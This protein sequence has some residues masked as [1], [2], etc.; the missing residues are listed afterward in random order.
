MMVSALS[1]PNL[2]AFATARTL[3]LR[4][5][6]LRDWF[7]FRFAYLF[8]VKRIAIGEENIPTDGPAI[9]IMN[10]IA[11]IDPVVVGGVKVR[12]VTPLAKK[13]VIGYP[14]LNWLVRSWG[15]IPVDRMAID[16]QALLQV[17]ALLKAGHCVLIAPEGT[18]HAAMQEFLAGLAYVAT[19]VPETVVV[20]AA[21]EGTD[22]F[23]GNL[24]RLRR[25]KIT[26]KYGPAF[27]F[28]TED[29]KRIP[30]DTLQRMS[31][32]AAY[33][34]AQMLDEH[35]QGVYSD[36]SKMTTDTLEFVNPNRR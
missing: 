9:L 10:H 31:H 27:R 7:L 3:H 8:L 16:R 25:T 22:Q 23:G 14:V 29:R 19:K 1:I 4:R 30:S 13:E 24:R 2:P 12:F 35:R 20:P 5:R 6:F 17:I 26:V 34:I 28:K 21:V 33:Q 32:E 15:V 11:F 18:R 36:L